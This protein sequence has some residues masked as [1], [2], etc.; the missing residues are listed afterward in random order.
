MIEGNVVINEKEQEKRKKIIGT[1]RKQI[2]EAESDNLRL[3]NPKKDSEMEEMVLRLIKR[4]AEEL[5]R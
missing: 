4:K 5:K 1:I 3:K 2:F